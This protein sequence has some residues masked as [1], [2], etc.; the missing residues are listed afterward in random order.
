MESQNTPRVWVGSAAMARH[1]DVHPVSL[2]NIRR[3]KNS[4]FV[5]GR[6]YRFTGPGKAR[7]QWHLESTEAAFTVWQTPEPAEVERFSRTGMAVTR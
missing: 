2:R 1:L 3:S 5:A 4:P 7:I 6:D